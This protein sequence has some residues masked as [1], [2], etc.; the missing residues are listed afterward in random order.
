MAA[1]TVANLIT[2]ALALM[3]SDLTS[4]DYNTYA[5]PSVNMMLAD[6]YDV[7][8]GLLE[9]A[10]GTLL[11]SI[12]AVTATTDTLTYDERLTR[13]VMPYGLARDLGR[14]DNN[15]AVGAFTRLYDENKRRY[16]VGIPEDIE[17]VYGD[18]EDDE[19]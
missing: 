19:E 9:S 6:L 18:T 12:P 17:D 3:G 14:M 8:N 4:T 2:A 13:N 15:P 7:N 16:T 5:I 10:D 11:T 1:V